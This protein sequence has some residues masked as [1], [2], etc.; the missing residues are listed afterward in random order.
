M[1]KQKLLEVHNLKKSFPQGKKQCIALWDIN[2]DLEENEVLGLVGESGCGKSL[3]ARTILSLEKKDAGKIIFKGLNLDEVSPKRFKHVRRNMQII[4]QDPY[5]SLN[6]KMTI[7]EIL[8]EPFTIHNQAMGKERE[9]RIDQLLEQ[10]GLDVSYKKRFPHEFSGGQR[11]RIGIARALALHPEFIICDEPLSS[12]DVSIQA[13][14]VNLLKKL[15]KDENLTYLF[16]SHDLSMVK[17]ISNRVCVMYLGHIF[18]IGKS[19]DIY[20]NPLHPY[21]QALLSSIPVADPFY[22]RKRVKIVLKGE[23]PSILN[24]SQGCP[25]HPRCPKAM[26]IC[27]SQK[28]VMKEI[29]SGHKVFCHL[30]E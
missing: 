9:E 23:T 4:F 18:E 5:A 17:Y 19:E 16:I 3:I 6:P 11:Q 13:Q 12:L 20:T 24:P 14:I 21:T 25:F 30:F 2:F 27:K 7:Q 29:Q 1:N 22:E 26:D 15:K 28:P 8:R 10:V